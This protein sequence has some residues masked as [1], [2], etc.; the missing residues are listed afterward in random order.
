MSTLDAFVHLHVPATEPGEARSL[1]VLHGTGGDEADLLPLA[2][3]LLP[4]AAILS[5]RGQVLE[6]G[7]PRFFR[8]HAEGVLDRD[9]LVARAHGLA[10]WVEAAAA[11]YGLDRRRMFALGYSNGANIAAAMLL[12]R[13][14]TV[15]GALLLRPMMLPL[16]AEEAG[17]LDGTPVRIASG[18]HDPVVPAGDPGRLAGLLRGAGAEVEVAIHPA[19]GHGPLAAELEA[20]AAWLERHSARLGAAV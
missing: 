9:D 16:G 6:R 19:A 15:A 17:A 7:M 3:D 8:R 12:L 2:S 18:A 5:P 13:P 11:R 14:G 10:G 1:L 20:S 4:G